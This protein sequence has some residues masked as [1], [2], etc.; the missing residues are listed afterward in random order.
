MRKFFAISLAGFALSTLPSGLVCG[1]A[2]GT[3]PG[4]GVEVA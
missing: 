1:Q 4:T 3:V 2:R